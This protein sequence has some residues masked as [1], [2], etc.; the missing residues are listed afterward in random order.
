VSPVS[1]FADL[2]VHT[3]TL[4]RRV[5]VDQYGSATFGA[6]T[7]FKCR[8]VGQE[9]FTRGAGGQEVVST[10]T[11]YILGDNNIQSVDRITLPDG[12][13]PPII[14]VRTY[15]DEFGTHHQEVLL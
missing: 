15:P 7:H 14:A 11:I 10:T 5:S 3:I 4:E 6:G 8:V 2:M 9:R 12:T 13:Q 1:P